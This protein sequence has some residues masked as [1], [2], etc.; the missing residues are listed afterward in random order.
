[1][2]TKSTWTD[3]LS[4]DVYH[5]L[6]ECR[7]RK[8]DLPMLVN[9]RWAWLKGQGK[10]KQGYTKEDALVQ[11]LEYLDCN[12]QWRLADLTVEEYDELKRE[13]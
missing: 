10:D 12:D 9:V 1:M 2:N 5:R 4:G 6:C 11:I 8:E 13:A 3:K 7:T